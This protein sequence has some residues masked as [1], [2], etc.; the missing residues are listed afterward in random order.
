MALARNSIDL[1]ADTGERPLALQDG[2]EEK[3]LRFVSSANVACGG[4]AGDATS[5]KAVVQ[6]C[7]TLGVGLGAHPGYPDRA[8][9]GRSKLEMPASQLEASLIEQ[10]RDLAEIAAASG[11]RVRHVKPHGALY[12]EASKNRELATI[13]ARSVAAV[14]HKFVLVGL[15]GS[16]MLEVWKTEGFHVIGEAFA[17]RRYEPDGSLRPRGFTDA[18]ITN[19]AEAAEQA[20]RI[21][22]EGKITA[23]DGTT[24]FVEAQTI[25]L[26]SDTSNALQIASEIRLR[27]SAAG[28]EV[29][30]F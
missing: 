9:F 25:C 13:I 10:M 1:N 11:L 16:L 12:N 18:L 6:I 14:D 22:S 2:S 7:R 20:L 5:M 28:I 21:A 8:G 24:F 29:T 19:P 23:F 3:L 26:H 27:L 17:D 15:A 30:S 4:H